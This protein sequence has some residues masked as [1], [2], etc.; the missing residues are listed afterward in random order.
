MFLCERVYFFYIFKV[1]Y[2]I[3]IILFLRRKIY[4]YIFKVLEVLVVEFLV[5]LF[6][7]EDIVL[8]LFLLFDFLSEL[9]YLIFVLKFV[10]Y[11]IVCKI[12]INFIKIF[13]LGY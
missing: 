10:G 2:S 13:L 6:E 4:K 7:F 11:F 12:C 3:Y 5:L 9:I 8:F 1:F